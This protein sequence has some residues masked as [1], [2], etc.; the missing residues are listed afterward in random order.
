MAE[1]KSD[2]MEET[3]VYRT[4]KKYGISGGVSSGKGGCVSSTRPTA[5]IEEKEEKEKVKKEKE[6][7]RGRY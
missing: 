4:K 5:S 6:K 7:R 1:E 3:R 2:Q